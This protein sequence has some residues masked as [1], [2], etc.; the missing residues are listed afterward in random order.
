MV[1][2]VVITVAFF[3]IALAFF[4]S[5]AAFCICKF[6][7]REQRVALRMITQPTLTVVGM[8]FSIL[9]GFFIAQAMK[10][11]SNA[12]VCAVNEANG[13]GDVFRLARGLPDNDR[14]RIRNLCRKYIDVVIDEEWQLMSDLKECDNASL[15]MQNL[16]DSILSVDPTTMREQVIYESSVEAMDSLAAYRRAR[17]GT[18]TA[19]IPAHL[20][21]II[22]MG[23][24]AIVALT[25]LF[26]PESRRFHV[27]I[28]S[29]LLIPL[30][31]NVFL[32]AEYSYPFAGVLSL[33]PTMFELIKKRIMT[34]DD[35]AP[36]YM[37]KKNGIN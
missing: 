5:I 28:L 6:I 25:F 11:Y 32:L 29:C 26:A 12:G 15:A 33:K 17:I 34:Q 36:K 16:Y 23:A 30:L 19:G 10:D 35:A 7:P 3:F 20:W 27:G 18:N 9:L 2:P 14:V 22:A 1:S 37:T 4:C 8:M 24:T 13:I 21:G 31:L